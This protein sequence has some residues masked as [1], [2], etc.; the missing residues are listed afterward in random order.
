[1]TIHAFIHALAASVSA[2]ITVLILFWPE[3]PV[4]DLVVGTTDGMELV[5]GSGDDCRAA[6]QN[7]VVPDNWQDIICIQAN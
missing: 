4:Y 5:I 2:A 3:P 7:A 6:W 1:M